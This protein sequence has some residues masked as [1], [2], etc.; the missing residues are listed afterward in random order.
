M[1]KHRLENN[2]EINLQGI[3]WLLV[4]AN[5]DCFEPLFLNNQSDALIIQFI[6]L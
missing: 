4:V 6:L 2:I 1:S 3:G 5:V